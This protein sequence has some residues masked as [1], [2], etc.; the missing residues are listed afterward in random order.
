M[1]HVNLHIYEDIA[2]DFSKTRHT[3]WQCVRDFTKYISEKQINP[4]LLEVGCG[5]GKNMDYVRNQSR[6]EIIGIDTCLNFIDI[7]I[8]KNLKALQANAK[9]LP[10]PKNTFDSVLCI[11]MF[12]HLLNEEDRTQS[13][14]EI[15]RV[16]KP[17]GYGMIT[18]WSTE[19]PATSKFTFTEGIN[20]VP[21]KSNAKEI[22]TRFYYV[23]SEQM[24]RD[25]FESRSEIRILK[26]YN[27][28]G[29]WILIFQKN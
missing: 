4:Y 11:A 23:Y 18:C 2:K 7:C 3:V 1:E 9:Q 13:F 24:F 25:T 28:M 19:Q 21:W 17:N 8:Q 12:H 20:K 10:F 15:L 29:N 26:L 14:N 27:E 22:Q 16:L 6:Y 5:N